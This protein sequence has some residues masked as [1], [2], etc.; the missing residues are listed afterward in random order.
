M[1]PISVIFTSILVG[2]SEKDEDTSEPTSQTEP[3]DFTYECENESDLCPNTSTTVSLGGTD[4]KSYLN[5]EEQLTEDSCLE[6]CV[7]Q[8]VPSS[9]NI[10]SCSYDGINDSGGYDVTCLTIECAV[11]GRAHGAIKK[12]T[13]TSGPTPIAHW[14]ARAFHG[15]AS[16][17][18][19]FSILASELRQHNAPPSLAKRCMRAA[20]EEV[21]HA[22]MM[23]RFCAQE[24]GKAS[25]LDFGTQTKRGIF[26]LAMDNAV[27]GCIFETYA[28]LRARYQSLHAENKKVRKIMKI[29]ARD[30]TAHAQLAWDI[31]SWIMPQLSD[32]Q[33]ACVAKEQEK[34]RRKLKESVQ[35][36]PS[37][38]LSKE[39]GLPG[40]ELVAELC[41]RLAA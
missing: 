17:V 39:I 24:G 28:A 33:R 26:E 2:C 36:S 34:A 29:I 5:D 4:F 1:L 11:E 37:T 23:S 30:E 14:L 22:R 31:H 41:V 13:M 3:T 18:A 7:D 32:E 27:E 8:S 40:Q 20:K 10:C 6:I 35:N 12:A 15:E 9:Y 21:M 25:P 19:A 38:S 16:S